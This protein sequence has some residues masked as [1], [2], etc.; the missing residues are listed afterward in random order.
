M[1]SPF[2][3]LD[4]V[5]AVVSG[6]IG[7]H[8]KNPT[9]SEVSTGRTGHI[10]AVKITYDPGKVNYS[11]L[12]AVFWQQ[13]DPTD[14]GGQFSDRG[15]QYTTA[16][17]YVDD[18]QKQLAENS[19]KELEDSGR[20]DKPIVTAIIKAGKFFK[21]EDYH[22]DYYKTYPREYERY[23]NNSGR[24]QYLKEVWG[25]E[26]TEN[27]NE[28]LKNILTPMQYEVTQNNWTEQP[29]NNK[30][31]DNK[32]AGVYVDI[33]SGEPLFSSRDKFDSNTGWPSFTKPLEP[34]N[35]VE[36]EDSSHSTV[37]TEVRSKKADSHLGH[38]FKDGP[39]ESGLRYCIN[40]AALRFIPVES[41]EKEG[42]GKYK[43]L[44][45]D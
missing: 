21:A 16:I 10:E 19:K 41:L 43:K 12:L 17:F 27:V 42:Y 25:D 15:Q 32:E 22:Q 2:E 35:I 11:K 8:T 3:K 23:R 6:Y 20:F 45:V 34:Q 29:F 5:V 18:A 13:V 28:K 31:W 1:E 30:Y 37:R 4:G 44:F 24:N 33:V 38:L 7:G 39:R 26:K 9:Y 40:S 14:T 36:K